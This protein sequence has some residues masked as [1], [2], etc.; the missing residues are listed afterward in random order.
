MPDPEHAKPAHGNTPDKNTGGRLLFN[1][2]SILNHLLNLPRLDQ[3]SIHLSQKVD[4]F[5]GQQP[6]K[7]PDILAQIHLRHN[8]PLVRRGLCQNQLFR[9]GPQGFQDQQGCFCVGMLDFFHR[10]QGRTGGYP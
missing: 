1:R 8:H 7:F 9:N 2:L 4:F 10:R 5:I 6:L 3:L